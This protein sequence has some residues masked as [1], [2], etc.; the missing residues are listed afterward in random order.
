VGGLVVGGPAPA[1]GVAALPV[2]GAAA[3]AADGD[4][5]GVTASEATLPISEVGDM[6][7]LMPLACESR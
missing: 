4:A 1:T 6:A 3:G 5:P 7:A 2:S